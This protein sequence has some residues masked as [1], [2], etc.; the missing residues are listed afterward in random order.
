ML[1]PLVLALATGA[2]GGGSG[3][4]LRITDIEVTGETDFGSLEVEVHL[5]DALDHTFLGCAG[6]GEGLEDVDASDVTYA[7]SAYFRGPD[8]DF[9][10]D[11]L[12]LAGRSI[13]VQVIEDDTDPCPAPPGPDDDVIGIA[14]GIDFYAG[15]TVAFEDVTLLRIAVE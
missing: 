4:A 11:P 14:T 8:S 3:D 1:L 10:I 7:V 9:E 6:Q 13:E 15:Q 2:C 5:F 12:D